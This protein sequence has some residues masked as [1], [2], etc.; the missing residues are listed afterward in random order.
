MKLYE[1]PLAL[2]SGEDGM[3]LVNPLVESLKKERMT[4][5]DF[6]AGI[7]FSGRSV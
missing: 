6:I 2:Q 5:S 7:E 4:R 3:Y 1:D